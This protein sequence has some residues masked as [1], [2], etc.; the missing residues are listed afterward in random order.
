MPLPEA[1]LR[2]LAEEPSALYEMPIKLE[3]FGATRRC[4]ELRL[5]LNP[6]AGLKAVM[7]YRADAD[8]QG[9]S[10]DV[11]SWPPWRDLRARSLLRPLLLGL[12]AKLVQY[13][14]D[15]VHGLPASLRAAVRFL[16]ICITFS[17]YVCFLGFR[18]DRFSIFTLIFVR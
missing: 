18:V 10:M 6:A 9:E 17:I 15:G 12:A 1:E 7:A 11:T 4:L 5:A 3:G 8:R 2:S 13:H 16:R 14:V